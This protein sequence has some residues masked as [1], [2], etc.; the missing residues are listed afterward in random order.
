MPAFAINEIKTIGNTGADYTTLKAAFDAVNNGTLTG[1]VTLRIIANT[2]ETTSATL[3]ASG[4]GSANYNT[5]NIYPTAAN[6]SVTGNMN[7]PLIDLNGADNVTFDGRINATGTSA[8]L[9]ISN[10]SN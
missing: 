4:T 3:N 9:T 8:S 1:N 6:L 10:A 7:A 2:T 5:I